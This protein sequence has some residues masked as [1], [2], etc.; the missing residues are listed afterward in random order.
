MAPLV[1]RQNAILAGFINT[2]LQK[3]ILRQPN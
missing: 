3:E 2:V 1:F